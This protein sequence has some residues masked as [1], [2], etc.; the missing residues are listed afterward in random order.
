M[1]A[2]IFKTTRGVFRLLPTQDG[3]SLLLDN[4]RLAA[5]HD[6]PSA[7]WQLFAGKT[8]FSAVEARELGVPSALSGWE[9]H[10]LSA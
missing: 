3:Y 6:A 1:N 4:A 5:G 10:P 2:Y 7:L 8:A 9:E